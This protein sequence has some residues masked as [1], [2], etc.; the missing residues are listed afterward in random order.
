M[1]RSYISQATGFDSGD[2][3]TTEQQV[4]EYFTVANM[5]AMFGECPQTQVELDAMADAAIEHRWHMVAPVA[6]EAYRYAADGHAG[7]QGDGEVIMRGTLDECR[8]AVLERTTDFRCWDGTE[9]DIE[10]YHESDEEGC[11][12]WAI[13]PAAGDDA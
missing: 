6:Y 4:R 10:A 12:G 9:G 8:G 5:E 7:E 13:R 1:D 11:G 3:F 2:E